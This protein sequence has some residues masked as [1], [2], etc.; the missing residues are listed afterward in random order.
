MSVHEQPTIYNG[1]TIYNTGG[2]GGGVLPAG[3][4]LYNDLI[5]TITSS[6]NNNERIKF[7]IDTTN[8]SLLVSFFGKFN[9]TGT[10][11]IDIGSDRT[12]FGIRGNLY[13][14][15]YNGGG[16]G[17]DSITS[18]YIDKTILLTLEQNVFKCPT[19]N[20]S[21]Q[22]WGWGSG[23]VGEFRV[24]TYRADTGVITI[25]RL[26]FIKNGETINNFVPA[27]IDSDIGLFDTI[28]NTMY[29]ADVQTKWS[30]A[31]RIG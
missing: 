21:F 20:R 1:P 4:E 15:W 14:F 22:N 11:E 5:F 12:W 24:P 28:S 16:N 3:L 27:K 25:N 9:V 18:E 8:D 31:N 17:N 6:V 23:S 7:N 10:S 2:G 13:A 19:Y 29:C 30:V 26:T